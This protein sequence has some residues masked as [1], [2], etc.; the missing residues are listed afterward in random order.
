MKP[1][2]KN[3]WL[4]AFAL[5]L[6]LIVYSSVRF[7]LGRGNGHSS[8]TLLFARPSKP[9]TERVAEATA[10]AEAAEASAAKAESKEK[11]AGSR[12]AKASVQDRPDT[13]AKQD[14]NDAGVQ[15]VTPIVPAPPPA[16]PPQQQQAAQEGH[17]TTAPKP[18]PPPPSS[19][20]SDIPHSN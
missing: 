15:P 9:A 4:K 7:E 14:S 12:R 11:R 1:I 5:A 16:P 13:A 17:S 20:P 10:F 18:A 2:A 6:A 3:I 19:Y 8:K